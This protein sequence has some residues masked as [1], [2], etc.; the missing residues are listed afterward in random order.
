MLGIG[1]GV[2]R[3]LFPDIT[4][5]RETPRRLRRFQ[6]PEGLDDPTRPIDAA[7]LRQACDGRDAVVGLPSPSIPLLL[8]ASQLCEVR[9]DRRPNG[10]E[11]RRVRGAAVRRSND[12][13]SNL[14]GR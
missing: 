13:P 9:E 5:R 10:F 14:G 6:P 3:E 1:I 2:V 12:G 11:F 7:V 8:P 4:A